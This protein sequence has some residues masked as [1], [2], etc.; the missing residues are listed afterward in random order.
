M[1]TIQVLKDLFTVYKMTDFD[2]VDISKKPFVFAACTDEE[3]SLI[4]PE[5]Y[6]ISHY[7]K[8]EEMY[9]CLRSAGTFAFTEVGIL[10]KITH[11]LAEKKI[12]LL[13]VSTFNTDYIFVKDRDLVLA[14]LALESLGY[15]IE[16][17]L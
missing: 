7:T 1:R 12:P 8:K 5:K 11:A 2:E 9:R 15:V 17:E 13:A 4:C 14:S 6:G 3:K 16:S 10:A